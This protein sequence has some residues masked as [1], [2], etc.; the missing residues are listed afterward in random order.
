MGLA[1]GATAETPEANTA[2]GEEATEAGAE[3]LITGATA[4][5]TAADVKRSPRPANWDTMTR[6][7]RRN[8]KQR[9]G[10]PR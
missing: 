7:Q 8:W 3:M 10:K 5:E 2:V 4:A 9:G 6:A 1:A